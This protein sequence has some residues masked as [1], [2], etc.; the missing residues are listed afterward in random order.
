[1]AKK[2]A[3]NTLGGRV[4]FA[5]DEIGLNPNQAAKR[6]DC[7]PQAIYMLIGGA[8]KTISSELAFSLADLTGF[9]ARWIVTGKGPQRIATAGEG[10]YV[11]DKRVARI[12]Q[13]LLQAQEE[14]KEYLV[15]A[16]HQS[17]GLLK[18]FAYISSLN[19][20]SRSPAM[21]KNASAIL[22]AAIA[23][24]AQGALGANGQQAE[25]CRKK[26]VQ[27]Q[28]LEVLYDMDWNLPKEPRVVAGPTFFNMPFDAKEGF[29]ETANCY[30]VGGGDKCVNFNVTHWKTGKAVGRFSNCKFKMN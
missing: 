19:S 22:A 8:S 1:M 5:L 2:Y 13:T 3:L 23:L 29:V 18:S 25:E 27:A 26:L 21:N 12:A 28:K 10:L 16:T 20:I 9:E 11:T 24:F 15:D 17:Q 4:D 6:M 7:T 30:L 14:G